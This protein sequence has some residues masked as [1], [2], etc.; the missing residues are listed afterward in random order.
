MYA[1]AYTQLFLVWTSATVSYVRKIAEVQANIAYAHLWGQYSIIWI[2]PWSLINVLD[3]NYFLLVFGL[4]L[5]PCDYS[6]LHKFRVI[7]LSSIPTYLFV[8]RNTSTSKRLFLFKLSRVPFSIR[9][10]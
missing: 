8:F 2:V 1:A 9:I 6:D 10:T 5:N 7:E 3:C 4:L